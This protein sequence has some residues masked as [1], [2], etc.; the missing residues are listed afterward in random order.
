MASPFAFQQAPVLTVRRL[1]RALRAAGVKDNR[2]LPPPVTGQLD[3]ATV[4]AVNQ[5]NALTRGTTAQVLTRETILLNLDTILARLEAGHQAVARRS[6]QPT[7]A[8]AATVAAGKGR[9]VALR[10]GNYD[11]KGDLCTPVDAL[12]KEK[13][14]AFQ[15]A[16]NQVALAAHRKLL[17]LTGNLG[18]QTAAAYQVA[19]RAA[20]AQ[21]NINPPLDLASRDGPWLAS[22]L[23]LALADVV[24]SVAQTSQPTRTPV[25]QVAPE[26]APPTQPAFQLHQTAHGGAATGNAAFKCVA[27]AVQVQLNRFG[28]RLR[29]DGTIGP[30]TL[31]SLKRVLG[32][33]HWTLQ[34]VAREVAAFARQVSDLA[35]AKGYPPPPADA[36]ALARVTCALESSSPL[37]DA[38]YFGAAPVA[39]P[40]PAPPSAPTP[41][42]AQPRAIPP[43]PKVESLQKLLN[44][45]PAQVVSRYAGAR[46]VEVTGV[47]DESDIAAIRAVTMLNLQQQGQVASEAQIAGINLFLVGTKLDEVTEAMQRALVFEQQFYGAPSPATPG[48]MT[49]PAAP[50]PP[51]P[52]PYQTTPDGLTYQTIPQ[53]LVGAGPQ[54]AAFTQ[55]VIALQQQLA[56]IVAAAQAPAGSLSGFLGTMA[57]PWYRWMDGA[58]GAGPRRRAA[59]RVRSARAAPAPSSSPAPPSPQDAPVLTPGVML[60]PSG[61][62]DA[63]TVSAFNIYVVPRLQSPTPQ[64]AESLAHNLDN[65]V[66]LAQSVATAT[67]AQQRAIVPSPSPP[68]GPAFSP[69][70]PS[71]PEFAPAPSGPAFSPPPSAPPAAPS[72]WTPDIVQ[73]VTDQ[74]EA[75]GLA[76]EEARAVV[77][78]AQQQGKS[79][80]AAQAMVD[81]AVRSLP[82]PPEAAAAPPPAAKFPVGVAIGV[83]AATLAAVGVGIAI[84]SIGRSRRRASPVD[85]SRRHSRREARP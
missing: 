85:Q 62:L 60:S 67:E 15:R 24:G 28:Q 38:R 14:V 30:N 79:P 45:F 64:T 6:V 71:V 44:A 42:A 11:C 21:K 39:R 18:P 82:P 16:L 41:P 73:Q 81:A 65:A 74:A 84:G 54:G 37:T 5:W 48:A 56:R 34:S 63:G 52:P 9:A 17:P 32:G 83:G 40:T 80:A 19:V 33:D 46:A 77:A 35:D 70:P 55:R 12:A 8:R 57:Q 43:S 75:Q 66:A 31:A 68:P 47:L 7:A 36:Y 61:V 51:P 2:S 23:D 72:A 78:T 22:H 3:E 29:I 20:S 1:Q 76:P 49:L 59:R 25:L 4:A 10:V 26:V 50:A 27:M 69:P 53:G 13:A 58:L